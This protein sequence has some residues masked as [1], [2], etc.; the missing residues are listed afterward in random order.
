MTDVDC[1]GQPFS[2]T[3][4]HIFTTFRQTARIVSHIP[5]MMLATTTEKELSHSAKM[6]YKVFEVTRLIK[7]L[8]FHFTQEASTNASETPSN[9]S[10]NPTRRLVI[11]GDVHG[12]RSELESL[13]EKV[14]FEQSHGDRLILVGDL[15]NKG[16][17][18]PGVIDLA[19]KL[20]ADVVRGNHDN[21]VLRAAA[22]QRDES[23][24]VTNMES[25]GMSEDAGT[26]KGDE[27][28]SA[29]DGSRSSATARILSDTQLRWLASL[30]LMLRIKLSA[31]ALPDSQL[32]VVHAG[33]VPGVPLE[34]QDPYA[35]MHMRS[36]ATD[37]NGSVT[38]A[39][40]DGDETWAISWDT[41]QDAQGTDGARTTVVYG[42]DAMRGLYWGK[43]AFGLDSS[44]VYG[45]R[46]SAMVM[47]LTECGIEKRLVQVEC[48]AK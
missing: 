47:E 9:A 38:P 29:K 27:S 22:A 11:V 33:L 37:D 36:L 4:G 20:G 1:L 21:A 13:L 17:D 35:V 34:Q 6:P 48:S 8:Y 14:G 30:P 46:L 15:V 2:R 32:V 23:A 12:M 26:S 19:M 18:S 31:A 3:T 24:A 28:A 44:C 39:E 10:A 16:P 41:W 7:D 42:H 40:A 43:Y 5:V 25:K 45:K